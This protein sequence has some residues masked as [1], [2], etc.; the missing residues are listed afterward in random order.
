MAQLRAKIAAPR[1]AIDALSENLLPPLFGVLGEPPTTLKQPIVPGWVLRRVYDGAAL[2]EAATHVPKR[3][4]ATR[5]TRA[6]IEN[7]LNIAHAYVNEHAYLINGDIL[8]M[9]NDLSNARPLFDQDRQSF[10][11]LLTNNTTHWQAGSPRHLLEPS[12]QFLR[13]TYC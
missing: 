3:R 7:S 12:Q 1:S 6:A 10:F 8:G 4:V 9:A 5:P 11:E 2:I 13:K